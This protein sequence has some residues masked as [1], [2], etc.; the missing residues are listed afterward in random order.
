[1]SKVTNLKKEEVRKKQEVVDRRKADTIA[2]KQWRE[3][4]GSSSS[5]K[6]NGYN[7][8]EISSTGPDQ[9]NSHNN[10]EDN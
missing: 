5:I 1:M 7:D 3:R 2:E 9:E 8:S 4:G 10:S 6:N